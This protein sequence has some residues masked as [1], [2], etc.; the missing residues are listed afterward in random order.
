MADYDR[1]TK[2]VEAFE[3]AHS[4]EEWPRINTGNEFLYFDGASRDSTSVLGQLFNA[5]SSEDPQMQ[6][7]IAS[8]KLR[9]AKHF[10]A[11]AKK[12]LADLNEKLSHTLPSDQDKA[13]A[14]LKKLK[15][16]VRKASELL[17]QREEEM[18]ETQIGQQAKANREANQKQK[19]AFEAWQSR[20]RDAMNEF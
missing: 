18:G 2:L 14:D 5:K 12:E 6:H 8:N 19:Q 4:F 1:A 11:N 20:R 9:Y 16:N 10:L 7:L 17:F 13:I 3:K 15:A